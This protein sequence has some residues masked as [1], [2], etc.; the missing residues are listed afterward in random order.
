LTRGE[1]PRQLLRQI[2]FCGV[3]FKKSEPILRKILKT[4]ADSAGRNN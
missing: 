4:N 1:A 3:C 2:K